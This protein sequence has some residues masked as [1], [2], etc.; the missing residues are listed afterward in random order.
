MF[1]KGIK[2]SWLFNSKVI[3]ENVTFSKVL[4][5]EFF[6]ITATPIEIIGATIGDSGNYSCNISTVGAE[7]REAVSKSLNIVV[8]SK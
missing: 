8:S 1:S 7:E 4:N 2:I 5:N 6:L 3:K